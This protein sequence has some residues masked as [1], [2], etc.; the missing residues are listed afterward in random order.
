MGNFYEDNDDLRFYIEK[1]IDWEPLVK[2]TEYN[3]KAPDAFPNKEEALEFYTSVLELAGDF[4]AE[5]IDPH[6]E[7]IDRQH[8]TLGEQRGHLPAGATGHH[9]SDQ[10]ATVA[11]HVPAA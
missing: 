5:Q 11:R 10:C 6:T 3:F 8:P 9:G 1:A 2:L 7:A 4:S